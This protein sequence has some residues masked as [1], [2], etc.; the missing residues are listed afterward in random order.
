MSL[1][2]CLEFAHRHTVNA[3]GSLVV[4]DSLIGLPHVPRYRQ[5]HEGAG[6]HFRFRLHPCRRGQF[7]APPLAAAGFRPS[8]PAAVAS[9]AFAPERACASLS[10]VEIMGPIGVLSCSA[11]GARRAYYGLG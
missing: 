3:G 8:P 9:V 7:S 5:L 10:S 6:D 1:Q 2:P 4:H 11:F